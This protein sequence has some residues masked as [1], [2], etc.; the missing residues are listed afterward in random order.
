MVDENNPLMPVSMRTIMTGGISLKL[1]QEKGR[2]PVD[3]KSKMEHFSPTDY[4]FLP[5]VPAK[6]GHAYHAPS[7][8]H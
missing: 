4:K 7:R 5:R 8:Y 1:F 3:S 2:F 6:L